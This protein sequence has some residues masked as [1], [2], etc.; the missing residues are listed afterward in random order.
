MPFAQ[1]ADKETRDK[2]VKAVT[3]YLK[4][5]HDITA[6]ELYKVWKALFYCMWHSDKRAVQADLAERLTGLIH[7]MPPANQ[8]LFVQV[9]WG[10]MAREWHG[11]DRLRCA[12]ALALLGAS[13]TGCFRRNT[14]RNSV[15]HLLCDRPP[16]QQYFTPPHPCPQAGQILHAYAS[17]AGP[18]APGPVRLRSRIGHR[19]P[20][21]FR[22]ARRPAQP[23]RAPGHPFLSG[24]QLSRGTAQSATRRYGRG[25]LGGVSR[26]LFSADGAG[27]GEASAHACD[28][29]GCVATAGRPSAVGRQDS[30]GEGGEGGEGRKGGGGEEGRKE[31]EEGEWRKREEGKKGEKGEKGSAGEEGAEGEEGQEGEEG[32]V[33]EEGEED[34]G[35]CAL[36]FLFPAL[37]D[38][39]F[40]LASDPSTREE[41]C[42]HLYDLQRTAEQRAGSAAGD[43]G[44]K[45]NT[46]KR[47]IGK[48][49]A[50][51]DTGSGGDKADT[52]KGGRKG[53]TG[54]GKSAAKGDTGK[55]TARADT[56]QRGGKADTGAI[57]GAAGKSA[58]SSGGGTS[59]ALRG[60]IDRAAKKG[61]RKAVEAELAPSTEGVVNK[62]AKGVGGKG[63]KEAAE[64]E[65]LASAAEG[66]VGD[67][68]KGMKRA[69][70]AAAEPEM[71]LATEDVVLER[72]KGLNRAKGAKREAA[73]GTNGAD[74]QAAAAEP[75]MASATEGMGVKRAKGMKG[76]KKETA[77]AAAAS[78]AFAKSKNRVAPSIN[79][80]AGAIASPV[81]GEAGEEEASGAQ[82][83]NKARGRAGD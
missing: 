5:A 7:V 70:A 31:G 50:K 38:R 75:E 79:S 6:L 65:L 56:A 15:T 25:D 40:D 76:T 57:G 47:S 22:P 17:S 66:K 2:A 82:K 20:I 36:P 4:G 37:S 41:N 44:G 11:I 69:K 39:L 8:P 46:D 30:G 27:G 80:D 10:T 81:D 28:G 49:G 13:S 68:A 67:P 1:C 77:I 34:P 3:R 35:L 60:M 72:A 58:R 83:K 74:A 55:G 14:R 71:A 64:P 51:G 48:G 18:H 52:G 26:A 61:E 42:S 29:A 45:A 78:K 53:D 32:E 63:V 43:G 12:G 62:R 73:K 19:D 9:F 54:E 21:R 23:A 16:V 33:G 24:G 59:E